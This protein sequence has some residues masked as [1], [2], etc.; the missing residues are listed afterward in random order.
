MLAGAHFAGMAIEQSM[1]GA[2]HACAN[3][4]TARFNIAARPRARDPAAARRP[5]ERVGCRAIATLPSMQSAEALATRLGA[6]C[7]G[8]RTWAARS[9]RSYGVPADALPGL[10]EQAAQQWTGTFNP[11][12]FDA[13]GAQEI[14]RAAPL[15]HRLTARKF[16]FTSDVAENAE[17]FGHGQHGFHGSGRAVLMR[18]TGRPAAPWAG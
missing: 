1:L 8:R 10:A 3:P 2:A 17:G 6:I 5:L 12:P 4:L 7:A 18:I 14:Y 13:A 16:V 11:R 15:I 9:P